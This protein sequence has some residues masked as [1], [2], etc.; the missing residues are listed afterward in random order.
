[1]I[2][3]SFTI[4]TLASFNFSNNKAYKQDTFK[5]MQE[6]L[7]KYPL[8]AFQSTQQK[9]REKNPDQVVLAVVQYFSNTQLP[10]KVKLKSVPISVAT[11][12]L[13][14][15]SQFFITKYKEFPK[16]KDSF[17]QKLADP[18]NLKSHVYG[19]PWTRI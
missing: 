5:Y 8:F 4:P 19:K 2:S 17:W 13:K 12:A 9:Y 11:L 1:M 3:T 6:M 10:T 18:I 7:K 16:S 14:A 15:N